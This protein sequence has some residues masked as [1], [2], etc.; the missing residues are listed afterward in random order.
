MST[1]A[2][3]WVECCSN[4]A[5]C[6][7]SYSLTDKYSWLFH[8]C[9]YIDV[10]WI[11]MNMLNA[12]LCIC[13][14]PLY[15]WRIMHMCML[16]CLAFLLCLSF[17]NFSI[18]L[19]C[20]CSWGCFPGVCGVRRILFANRRDGDMTEWYQRKGCNSGPLWAMKD[21]VTEEGL[22]SSQQRSEFDGNKLP[23]II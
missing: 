17:F 16:V 5:S 15:D 6:G 7:V 14:L 23:K 12:G 4:V 10:Q 21:V 11:M 2:S 9:N 3:G 8:L 13:L 20:L 22:H 1:L 18:D 19:F